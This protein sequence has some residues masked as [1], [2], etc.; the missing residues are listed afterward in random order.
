MRHMLTFLSCLL[1][2]A[3]GTSTQEENERRRQ[4]KAED[5]RRD[6]LAFKI[7]VMPTLDCLPFFLAKEQGIFDT[8]GVDVSLKCKDA[9][10]DCDVAMRSGQIEC[11]V[12]DLMRTE[13]LRKE[14]VPLQYLGATNAYWQMIGN[15]KARIKDIKSLGDKMVAMARYSATD[16]LATLGIDSVKPS[17]PVF[18]IQVND[19]QVRLM[20]L[21]N[22]E[23]DAVMLTEPQASW[24]RHYNHPVLMDSRDKDIRLGVIAAHK[25]R[26]A[27]DRRQ[28]QLSLLIKG[29]EMACDSLNE[30]GLEHYAFIIKKYC[31]ANEST[32]KELPRITFPHLAQPRQKDIDRTKSVNW[33]TS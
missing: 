14:G 11:M 8:L 6:S 1:L 15:R 33:R 22:N 3:C 13:R 23:M 32:V 20:M 12:S 17:N 28:K 19:V 27:D 7:A 30:K 24:A 21:L 26:I 18:R 5:M 2:L 31:R 29:Y 9:Q 10:M 16:Y 4:A 25:N